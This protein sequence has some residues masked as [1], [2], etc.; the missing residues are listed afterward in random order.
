MLTN[1]FKTNLFKLCLER[2]KG[3]EAA[4]ALEFENYSAIR[5]LIEYLMDNPKFYYLGKD[6]YNRLKKEYK[7]EYSIIQNLYSEFMETYTNHLDGR[8]LQKN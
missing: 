3:R 1:D 6:G 7:A 8:L 5:H 4:D 2:N